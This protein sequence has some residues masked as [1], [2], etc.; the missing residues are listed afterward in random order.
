MD[1]I[2]EKNLDDLAE[3]RGEDLFDYRIT[4][5]VLPREDAMLLWKLLCKA[6]PVKW[7]HTPDYT[8]QVPVLVDG[9]LRPEL[10]VFTTQNYGEA[11][12]NATKKEEG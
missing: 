2:P 1:K 3:V 10:T 4:G 8:A 6:I 12:L 5:V 11:V 7:E 9:P